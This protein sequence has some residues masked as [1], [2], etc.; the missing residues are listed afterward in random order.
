MKAKLLYCIG[1]IEIIGVSDYGA[2][3]T[4][5]F[6]SLESIDSLSVKFLYYILEMKKSLYFILCLT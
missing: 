5:M 4:L 3:Y 6:Y 1:F 2:K